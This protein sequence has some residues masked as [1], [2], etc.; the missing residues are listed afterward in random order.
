[1]AILYSSDTEE[2]CKYSET[3]NQLL[4]DCKEAVVSGGQY[5]ATFSL[6]LL[7]T[8]LASYDNQ[9]VFKQKLIL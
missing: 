1:M 7:P 4:T 2:K 5:Y 6:N 8:K 3:V 9:D